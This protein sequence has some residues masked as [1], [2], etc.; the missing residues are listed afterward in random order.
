MTIQNPTVRFAP[1]PTGKLHIGNARPALF[2][3]LYAKKVGGTFIL[4]FDDTDT[5][6]SKQEYADAILRDLG[7]LGITPDKIERQSDR[8][9]SYDAATQKL[10]DAGL[11]YPCYETSDELERQRKRR[12]ARGLPPVYD[13][14]G[15]K[16]SDEERAAL[17]AQ[18]KKPH[19]R[20]LLPNFKQTPFETQRTDVRWE[21]LIRGNQS[22]D[23]ASLSDPVLIREDGT[24]LYTLPSCVDDMDMGVTHIMRGDDH[25]TNSAV[26][27]ELFKALGMENL[28]TFAHH[29]L[30]QDKSGG[31]LSKRL[32]SLSLE[33]L[34]EA[35]YEPGAVASLAV[36][37]GTSKPVVAK[38]T[39]DELVPLFDLHM[40]TKSAAKFDPEDLKNLTATILHT[41]SYE[42]AKPRLDALKLDVSEA[43]WLALRE[44]L[45]TFSDI[46][47]WQDTIANPQKVAFSEEDSAYLQEAKT[48][49]PEGEYDASTWG[50]WTKALKEKTGRK[51]KAL[52][53][54]LRRALTGRE[55]G[56]DLSAILPILGRQEIL[57]RLS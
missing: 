9:E 15:L 55:H 20:F 38:A 39:L 56:P 53:M 25:V 40:V 32:G 7:W 12:L 47:M 34:R 54:P 52:F 23:L 18:G 41:T 1:S 42:K 13:R 4:R 10:K 6:R 8:I 19:W 3:W 57:A 51:G 48:L 28:P 26:Q 45:E 11:L 30:L 22:V 43:F 5:A 33:G 35:G 21:D 14:T 24:Y 46:K 31:G 36:L 44:N 17:E 50:I 37:I 49:L 16:Q 2:N 27:L 29:N